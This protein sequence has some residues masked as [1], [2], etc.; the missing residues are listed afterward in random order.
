MATD[1]ETTATATGATDETDS[2]V[3]HQKENE[4]SIGKQPNRIAALYGMPATGVVGSYGG[5]DDMQMAIQLLVLERPLAMID[6]E[7]KKRIHK[8]VTD[9]IRRQ[10]A[11][12]ED[13]RYVTYSIA[14]MLCMNTGY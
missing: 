7:L 6:D 4:F 14:C 10:N 13:K 2:K 5:G 11:I 9:V 3:S 12:P 8:A 1:P